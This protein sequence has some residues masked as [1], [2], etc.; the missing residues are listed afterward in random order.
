MNVKKVVF[1]GVLGLASI[2]ADDCKRKPQISEGLHT[3]RGAVVGSIKGLEYASTG[4]AKRFYIPL[5]WDGNPNEFHQEILQILDDFEEATGRE[6]I[7][8]SIEKNQDYYGGSPYVFG[9]WV[10]LGPPS[11]EKEN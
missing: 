2:G 5:G 10:G 3:V 4:K 1:W 6:I 7:S 11:F 8:W 9:I